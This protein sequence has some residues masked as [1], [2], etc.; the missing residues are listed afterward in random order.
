MPRTDD[1]ID[2]LNSCKYFTSLDCSNGYYQI[3]LCKESISK[4][5]F[6]TPD[7][8]YEFLRMPFGLVN[9]PA[10]FQKAMN[11]MLGNLRF[12]IAIVFMDDILIPSDS[13][14]NGFKNLEIIL[15]RIAS[16]GATLKLKKCFFFK[17][18]INYLGYEIDRNG[19][20]P[21]ADKIK[22]VSN[23]PT[24]TNLHEIRQFL[25]LTGYFRK[26]ILKYSLLAK[27]LQDL[28]K[29][30]SCFKWECDQKNAFLE[31][32]NK[33]IE[34]PIL[35]IYNREAYTELHTDACKWGI[36]AVLF[37]KQIDG[38]KPI[39]YLSHTT[40]KE[41]QRYH[42]YELETLAVV[43]ALTR[44]RVYLLGLEFK[45]ITDCNSLRLAFTKRDLIPRIGRWWMTTQEFNFTIE[46]R[47]GTS[48]PHADALSRNALKDE[49]LENIEILK[50][51]ISNDDWISA[52]QNMDKSCCYIF[53]VLKR[54]PIDKDEIRIH[55]EY[56]IKNER[57]YRITFNGPRW[58]VPKTARREVV[59]NNHDKIG[60][61]SVQKTLSLLQDKFWFP[62]MKRYVKRYISCCLPCAYNKNPTGKNIG[63]LYPIETSKEKSVEPDFKYTT[64]TS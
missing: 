8:H 41:E 27:P 60:H 12:S 15:E 1:E 33:L 31:L 37:Q 49:L 11:K 26:F 3:P 46:Y 42:S 28:L 10:V 24:P 9:A 23:F 32:K 35:A 29:K 51:D 36:G 21:G 48:I 2:R 22:A 20:R 40:T 63:L 13:I 58:V 64:Y 7:G 59:F 34:R 25:G 52:I 6:I 43:Y 45:I 44:F 16:V 19:V 56:V 53:E 4:T 5:A 54:I 61:F 39:A 57:L 38:L 62:E 30:D 18:K 14:K 55:Q 17:N 47:A 50:T